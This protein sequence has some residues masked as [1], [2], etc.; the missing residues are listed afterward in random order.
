HRQ[1][2]DEQLEQAGIIPG[3]IRISVG[4]ENS[5]DIINDLKLGLKAI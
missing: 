2:S 5:I 4:I 3:M 1:L